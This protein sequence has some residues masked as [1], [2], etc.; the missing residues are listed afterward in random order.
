MVLHGQ[1]HSIERLVLKLLLATHPSRVPYL[2]DIGLHSLKTPQSHT[3]AKQ[4]GKACN[5]P[6]LA[7]RLVRVVA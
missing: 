4:A 5:K 6:S 1:L 3:L 2:F 7:L